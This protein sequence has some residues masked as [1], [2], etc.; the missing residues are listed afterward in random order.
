M[1]VSLS[2]SHAFCF[3]H[4]YTTIVIHVTITT[5]IVK[6]WSRKQRHRKIE[7][8]IQISSS[9]P[10]C[11]S[12]R[13][14]A[15]NDFFS[16]KYCRISYD[17]SFCRVSSTFV[18]RVPTSGASSTSMATSLPAHIPRRL[19]SWASF[20]FLEN[21]SITTSRLTRW[22]SHK[23]SIVSSLGHFVLSQT[24]S[25]VASTWRPIAFF[26]YRFQGGGPLW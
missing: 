8:F 9:Y 26:W 18:S 21:H 14:K 16:H 10:H 24:S 2:L 19:L 22:R 17:S 12:W 23:L 3:R 5:T 6:Y 13:F 1:C 25:N 11:R 20:L 7:S 4:F 15:S